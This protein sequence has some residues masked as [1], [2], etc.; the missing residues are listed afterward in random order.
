[1]RKNGQAR[2]WW[3]INANVGLP[4]LDSMLMQ[5][6]AMLKLDCASKCHCSYCRHRWAL[7]RCSICMCLYL[8]DLSTICTK[9][10]WR[11]LTLQTA[12]NSFKQLQRASNSEHS[13]AAVLSTTSTGARWAWSGQT[14]PSS[15]LGEYLAIVTISILNTLQ[16]ILIAEPRM[17]EG[18]QWTELLKSLILTLNLVGN[19][20][21][22]SEVA[23]KDNWWLLT[24]L[25][26][27]CQLP[28]LPIYT[29]YIDIFSC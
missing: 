24:F 29:I 10:C 17:F 13:S 15:K 12:S 11:L 6:V 18:L 2:S 20:M 23:I 27:F 5:C 21:K 7:Q 26:I 9:C 8:W 3:R 4:Y 28:T 25:F 14:R 22:V 16:Y 1:M 19:G